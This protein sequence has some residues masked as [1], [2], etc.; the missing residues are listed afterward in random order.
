MDAPQT[1]KLELTV[2]E[3]EWL[4]NTVNIAGD[5]SEADPEAGT[6]SDKLA[7]AL[8]PYSEPAPAPPGREGEKWTR[9][10]SPGS[11]PESR[12]DTLI[13]RLTGKVN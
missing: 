11:M 4:F 5:S 8:E 10:A 1:V 9:P 13:Q 7:V 3:A 2:A 12:A 6:I